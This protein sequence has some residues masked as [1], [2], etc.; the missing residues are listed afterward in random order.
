MKKL[1]LLLIFS[2]GLSSS[3]FAQVRNITV[4]ELEPLLDESLLLV[5]VR[6]DLEF[7]QGYIPG[8]VNINLYSKSFEQQV[9]DYDRNRPVYVYCRTGHRSVT[10]ADKLISMG[11]REAHSLEGGMMRWQRARKPVNY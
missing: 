4:H 10:A 1:F 7:D 8:A 3:I 2:V 6:T 11:F 5:D 9:N